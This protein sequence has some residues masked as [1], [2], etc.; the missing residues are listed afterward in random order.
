M[1]YVKLISYRIQNN[2]NCEEHTCT[3]RKENYWKP[4]ILPPFLSR[5]NKTDKTQNTDKTQKRPEGTVILKCVTS[6]HTGFSVQDTR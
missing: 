3:I 2:S 1:A 5:N 6:L 4:V